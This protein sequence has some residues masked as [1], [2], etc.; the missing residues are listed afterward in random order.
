MITNGLTKWGGTQL[1]IDTTLVSPL[2]RDGQRRRAGRF[3]GA[4]EGT[5]LPGTHQG[6][7]WLFMSWSQRGGF[8]A[9]LL[10]LRGCPCSFSDGW[11]RFLA[12]ELVEE[13]GC[14]LRGLSAQN[15]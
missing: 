7:G 3:A 13:G 10:E 11:R 1:A 15:L 12:F 5:D 14:L 2:T 9:M 6:T 8:E 4:E